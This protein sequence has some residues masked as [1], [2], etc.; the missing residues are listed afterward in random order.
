VSSLGG[1]LP[2][3]GASRQGTSWSAMPGGFAPFFALLGLILVA[4]F[5]FA[6]VTG[7]LPSFP[8]GPNG[9][10]VRTPTP[11]GVVVIDPRSHVPGSIVYVKAGNLWIQSGDQARQLTSTGIDAMPTWS[12]DGKWI[13]FIRYN[14]EE[15]R[16][17]VSGVPRTYDLHVPRLERIRPDGTGAEA[18]RTGKFLRGSNIWSY[19]IRQP[20]ISPDGRTA[21][22]ISDGPDPTKS[23][24]VLKFI[25]IPSGNLTNPELPE[26]DG[27]GHQD[28]AWS[29]DGK[30]V[31]YV[32]NARDG[33]RGAPVILRY[34]LAT[35]KTSALTGPGYVAPAWSPDGRYVAAT[36][37][38]TF[39]TDIVVL[40]AKT[41]AELLRLTNDENS[42]APVW[43][44]AGDSIAFFRVDRGVV[45]LELVTL[46]GTAP[47]WMLG[48]TLALT[49]SAGLDA[50][51]HASWF[52]PADQ[53]PTPPPTPATSAPPAS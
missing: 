12:A 22:V 50:S 10:P 30:T 44:P 19:F 15:G 34:D 20:S 38:D 7:S 13:Y 14:E 2:P 37:T 43:S 5:S 42:F 26:I 6:L 40:D 47:R 35:K 28:P 9:G 27:L 31:L 4:G 18:I 29:P 1:R 33:T 36:R 48:D 49:L 11:S 52:I 23:D 39:G 53:L 46:K 16:W 17:P 21:A 41:G 3:R 51:S 24:L 32:K 8:G 25:Q 45:D